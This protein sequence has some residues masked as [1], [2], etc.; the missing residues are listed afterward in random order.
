MKTKGLFFCVL[1]IVLLASCEGGHLPPKVTPNKRLT[2]D[3]R[4]FSFTANGG[5]AIA[6]F[7]GLKDRWFITGCTEY[8]FV[9]NN[10]KDIGSTHDE[11]LGIT[12]SNYDLL[13]GSWYTAYK[14]KDDDGQYSVNELHI[15]VKP[16]D[17]GQRR[18]V[19]IYLG[20]GPNT[21]SIYV[22]QE[23]E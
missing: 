14:P 9:D 12:L 2:I 7:N 4:D 22:T 16:N 19:R 17:M 18:R 13:T 15:I 20:S 3:N 8:L 6:H 5:S 11:W 23:S 10:W 21:D 1:F